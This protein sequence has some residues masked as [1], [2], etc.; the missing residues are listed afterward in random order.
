MLTD[1]NERI[2][3]RRLKKDFNTDGGGEH[4]ELRVTGVL[5][6]EVRA[7]LQPTLI[8]QRQFIKNILCWGEGL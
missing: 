5:L 6:Y 3:N 1:V 8:Q 7:P 2:E 4:D